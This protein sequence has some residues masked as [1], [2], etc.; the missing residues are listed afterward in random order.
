MVVAEALKIMREEVGGGGS[1]KLRRRYFV[2]LRV[3]QWPPRACAQMGSVVGAATAAD[4]WGHISKKK[5][6]SQ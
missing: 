4:A 2:G 5:R 3:D 6:V 1:L